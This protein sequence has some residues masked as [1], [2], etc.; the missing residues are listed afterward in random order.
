MHGCTSSILP[1]HILEVTIA[2]RF[3]TCSSRLTGTFHVTALRRSICPARSLNSIDNSEADV[4]ARDIQD[5]DKIIVVLVDSEEKHFSVHQDAICDKSKFSKAAC[6]KHWIEGQEKL[7]R[8][9]EVKPEVFQRYSNW[10]YSGTILASRLTPE[11]AW[12]EV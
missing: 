12:Q 5:F 3:A 9:P 10:I 6:S 4:P 11:S 2:G 8:L 1:T 7:I